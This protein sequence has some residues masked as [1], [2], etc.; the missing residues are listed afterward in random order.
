[1]CEDFFL[2]LFSSIFVKHRFKFVRLLE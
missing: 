2:R 1:M